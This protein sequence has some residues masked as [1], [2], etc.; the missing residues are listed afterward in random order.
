MEGD[1]GPPWVWE[2]QVPVVENPYAFSE[3]LT[4]ITLATAPLVGGA[5]ILWREALRSTLLGLY[6]LGLVGLLWAAGLAFTRSMVAGFRVGEE[7]LEAWVSGFPGWGSAA[8]W[9]AAL[10]LQRL[11]PTG[12]KMVFL[13]HEALRLGWDEVEGA[14]IDWKRRRATVRGKGGALLKLYCNP[15]T[16]PQVL[17]YVEKQT[18]PEED[19]DT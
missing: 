14:S 15:A 7:G 11:S 12:S 18:S 8:A 13:G 17:E 9:R 19:E 6:G 2:A 3:T 16:A 5:A 10:V 4:I 1:Q